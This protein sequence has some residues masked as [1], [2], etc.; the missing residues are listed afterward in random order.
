[1]TTV[2]VDWEGIEREYRAGQLTLRKIGELYGVTEGAIRKRA[3]RDGWERDLTAKVQEAVRNKLVRSIGTQKSD[4]RT[5]GEIIAA[6]AMRGAD[7][8]LAHRDDIKAG[9]ELVKLLLGELVGESHT[10]EEIIEAIVA[11]T[12]S[13]SDV[14]RRAAM[15]K[16]VS[17]PTRA[18]T[19][20][21]LSSALKNLVGLERQAFNLDD[22]PADGGAGSARAMTSEDRQAEIAAL[23]AKVRPN[24][25]AA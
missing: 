22:T 8:V 4:P 21:S 1:M 7:V 25:G 13:P 11:D 17:L 23:L 18:G 19:L 6:A 12:P 15:M 9:R 2:Q 3:K 10:M 5:E 16:A 14:K 20:F 24:D